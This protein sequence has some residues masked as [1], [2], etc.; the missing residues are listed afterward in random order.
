ME[1]KI[2]GLKCCRCG[3][4]WVPR[5]KKKP[6]ICPECKSPYWDVPKDKK[7]KKSNFEKLIY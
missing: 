6:R 5:K 2:K 3:H 7:K 4:I 1:I